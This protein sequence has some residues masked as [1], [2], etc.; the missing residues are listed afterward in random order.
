[1]GIRRQEP[2][3]GTRKRGKLKTLP[4]SAYQMAIDSVEE[5]IVDTKLQLQELR[6][7]LKAFKKMLKEQTTWKQ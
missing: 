1:M 5:R 4:A 3:Q 7:R 6:E 2:S